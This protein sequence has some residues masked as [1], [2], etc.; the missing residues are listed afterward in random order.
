MATN[1]VPDKLLKTGQ[2]RGLQSYNF[3]PINW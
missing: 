2:N 1:S 3:E